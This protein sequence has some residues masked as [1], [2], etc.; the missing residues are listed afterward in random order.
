MQ[1]FSSVPRDSRA[2][3]FYWTQCRNSCRDTSTCRWSS[4]SMIPSCGWIVVTEQ[5]Q[6]RIQLF[7]FIQKT[8]S[9]ETAY[10]HFGRGPPPLSL[11]VLTTIF[12]VDLEVVV[13]TGAIIRAKLQSNRHHQQTKTQFL[14]GRIAFLSPNQQCQSTK[15]KIS[16]EEPV[17]HYRSRLVGV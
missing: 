1:K 11:S 13:T 7:H 12:Q 2:V 10:K 3:V 14:T 16:E 17:N 15:G 8:L 4:Y 5:S 6:R 9:W